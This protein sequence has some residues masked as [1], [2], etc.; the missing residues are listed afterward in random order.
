MPASPARRQ[1]RCRRGRARPR[2]EIGRRLDLS[3][4][5]GRAADE[6]GDEPVGGA[7]VQVLLRADLPHGAVVHDDQPVGH[8]QRL[9]LVVRDHDGRE[10]ELPL[11]LADLDAN[12]LAQLGIEVGERLVEQ[13]HVGPEDERA[14]QRHTLLLAAG[15]L[16]RQAFAPGARAARAAAPRRRG[17]SISEA[18]ILRISSPK[19]TFCATVRCGKSA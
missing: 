17:C 19:A 7:L 13:Q 10:P 8:G 4:D 16:P 2:N 12:L 5:E 9:L 18:S 11:Q 15:Q 3:L 6:P 1:P 14:G